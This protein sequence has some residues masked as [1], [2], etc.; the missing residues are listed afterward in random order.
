MSSIQLR[1]TVAAG[2]N[3]AIVAGVDNFRAELRPDINADEVLIDQGDLGNNITDSSPNTLSSF[4]SQVDE[5]PIQGSDY[6]DVNWPAEPDGIDDN[7]SEVSRRI[8]I[9]RNI[10][11]VMRRP[12]HTYIAKI[13]YKSALITGSPT[14]GRTS[15]NFT[16]NIYTEDNGGTNRVMRFGESYT[17]QTTMATTRNVEIDLPDTTTTIELSLSLIHISEPR[18]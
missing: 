1:V 4:V 14:D 12:D 13:T 17:G 7:G 9:H 6:E 11:N 10:Q 16:H 2:S 5:L 3:T 18:D 15:I 8:G